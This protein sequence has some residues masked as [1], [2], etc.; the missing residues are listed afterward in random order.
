MTYISRKQFIERSCSI[1]LLASSPVLISSLFGCK[2]GY[3]RDSAELNLGEVQDLLY[4][5]QMIRD[6]DIL[7]TRDNNGWSALSA[8]CTKEGCALSYQ[9]ERFLCTCCS[10]MFDHAGKVL[11]GPANSPLP[12]FEIRY[13]NGNLYADTSKIVASTYRFTSPE[14]EEA[15]ARLDQRIKKEGTREGTRIPEILLGKGDP[16]ESGPM[17]EE[18]KLPPREFSSE[19]SSELESS[20]ESE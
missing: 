3:T 18:K 16:T 17:F 7:V 2:Q 14:L 1:L 11:K 5:Q 9:E 19:E 6:R 4:T 10:S 13:T 15:I 20:E 8:Q 12:Y